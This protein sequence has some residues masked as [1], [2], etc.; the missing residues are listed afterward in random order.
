MQVR[1]QVRVQ[2][3]KYA[4]ISGPDIGSYTGQDTG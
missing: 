1:I 3:K 2:V 4:L